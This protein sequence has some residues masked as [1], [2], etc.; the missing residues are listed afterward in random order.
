MARLPV[1][2]LVS[3]AVAS[4]SAVAK[5]GPTQW[6]G[7]FST[8]AARYGV[9]PLLLKAI[10]RQESSMNPRAIGRNTNGTFDIG[11]MQIN[12]YHLRPGSKL[13]RAGITRQ[14][15]MDPCT[16]I[17][18]GAW[19]LADAVGRYGMSW[20]AVGVYHSPTPWRQQDYAAKVSRHLAREIQAVRGGV[21]A[22]ASAAGIPGVQS[23]AARRAGEPRRGSSVVWEPSEQ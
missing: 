18:V 3:L 8:A 17:N 16:N 14:H 19:V 10:A 13:T 4:P 5:A 6:D 1:A 12:T 7:C 22:P 9:H 2:L 23:S 11:L 20:K 21:A 15:L